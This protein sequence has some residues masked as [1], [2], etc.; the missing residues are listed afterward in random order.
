MPRWQTAVLIGHTT[1]LTTTHA[2]VIQHEAVTSDGSSYIS[3]PIECCS[4]WDCG[5][6]LHQSW[7]KSSRAAA[8]WTKCDVDRPFWNSCPWSGATEMTPRKNSG[9]AD[10]KRMK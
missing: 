2:V 4:W 6:V 10:I 5:W 8:R 3:G 9:D 7:W 1:F